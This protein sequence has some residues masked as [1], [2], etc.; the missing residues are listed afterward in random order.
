MLTDERVCRFC[1]KSLKK[2]MRKDA[3][4]C[5]TYCRTAYNNQR[6]FGT[7]PEVTRVDKILHR[8]LEIL[9]QVIKDRRYAEVSRKALDKAGFK[10]DFC[11]FSI[12]SYK[13]CYHLSYKAITEEKYQVSVVSAGILDKMKE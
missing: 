7:D 6:R 9:K 4:F 12:G 2:D 8:N 11:T 3:L 5:N 10:F 13:Y 1:Q